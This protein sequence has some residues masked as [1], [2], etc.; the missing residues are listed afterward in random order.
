M[1]E[2][3]E[4]GVPLDAC[5]GEGWYPQFRRSQKW[6]RAEYPDGYS[7]ELPG[8]HAW[9]SLTSKQREEA[10]SSLFHSYAL[11]IHDE[12]NERRLDAK[13]NDGTSYLS[14]GDV[15]TLWEYVDDKP[16]KH[17]EVRADRAALMNVLCE[18]E[19]LQHRLTR[20]QNR[21]DSGESK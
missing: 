18:I 19:L 20:F 14:P 9:D 8:R 5:E 4:S 2:I 10:L 13:A 17:G 21:D 3:D 11:L 12:D 6:A 1:S 16:N 15:S 7:I